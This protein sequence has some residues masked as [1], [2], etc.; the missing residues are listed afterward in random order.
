MLDRFFGAQF[1]LFFVHRCQE[2]IDKSKST[3]MAELDDGSVVQYQ[4][5][6]NEML[7]ELK[8]AHKIRQE[9]LSNAAEMYRNRAAKVNRKHEELLVAY[10]WDYTGL[11]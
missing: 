1:L 3:R 9:Q 7:K 8:R 2:F 4:H 11:Q 6:V 10:R 5:K